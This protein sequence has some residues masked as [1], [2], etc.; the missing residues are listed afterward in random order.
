MAQLPDDNKNNDSIMD[1]YAQ[2]ESK[3]FDNEDFDDNDS[4]QNHIDPNE[5]ETMDMG[6][7]AI[8]Q[9]RE[10][11]PSPTSNALLTVSTLHDF[12]EANPPQSILQETQLMSQTSDGANCPNPQANLG[13]GVPDIMDG[14]GSSQVPPV[15]ID[16]LVEMGF[17]RYYVQ[18]CIFVYILSILIS[19]QSTTNKRLID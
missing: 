12:N 11:A 14:L 18:G 9:D 7:H 19:Q 10:N 5:L 2:Q 16:N 8:I 13:F 1:S 3:Q 15:M 4:L 17:T 6:H